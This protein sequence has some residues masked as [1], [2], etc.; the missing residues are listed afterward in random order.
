MDLPVVGAAHRDG[1]L[2]ANLAVQSLGLRKAQ[3][4]SIG[5]RAAADQAGLLC[6][7]AQVVFVTQATDPGDREV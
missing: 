2:V 7:K 3:V 5:R 1:E 4:V 6:H